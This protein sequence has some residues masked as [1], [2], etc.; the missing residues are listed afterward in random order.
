MVRPSPVT[1]P[2]AVLGIEHHP[3]KTVED[4]VG[5]M[6]Q[7]GEFSDKHGTHYEDLTDKDKR[8]GA[9]TVLGNLGKLTRPSD[10]V[11]AAQGKYGFVDPQT[12]VVRGYLGKM[13]VVPFEHANSALVSAKG[14]FRNAGTGI[15]G[16][17]NRTTGAHEHAIARDEYGR[18]HV[19]VWHHQEHGPPIPLQFWNSTGQGGKT[20][21][22]SGGWYYTP[23]HSAGSKWIGKLDGHETN[24]DHPV[25]QFYAD[26]LNR[27]IGNV[28]SR[29]QPLVGGAEAE[30]A[31]YNRLMS[32]IMGSVDRNYLPNFSAAVS[33][34]NTHPDVA[35]HVAQVGGPTTASGK[36]ATGMQAV[37]GDYAFSSSDPALKRHRDQSLT[38]QQIHEG[39]RNAAALWDKHNQWLR[40]NLRFPTIKSLRPFPHAIWPNGR[41]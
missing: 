33:S 8:L 26:Q 34:R 23:G 22:Q 16:F 25:L 32:S 31:N 11:A 14:D 12:G 41:R 18:A 1:A 13:P 15:H 40:E 6:K 5:V 30:N 3:F 4:H 7:L 36:P 38:P 28:S 21:T 17:D 29:K 39:M 27:Q 2:P 19:I 9:A 20:G 37:I 10:P 35:A 24:Y